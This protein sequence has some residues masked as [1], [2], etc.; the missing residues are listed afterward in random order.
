[1]TPNKDQPLIMTQTAMDAGFGNAD[2]VPIGFVIAEG[3]DDT[4]PFEA[5]RQDLKSRRPDCAI[6][7]H[8]RVLIEH[9]KE[10]DKMFCRISGDAYR[11]R[12]TRRPVRP[13]PT[14]NPLED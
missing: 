10:A 1:M 4:A 5:A 11:E 6:V 8:A 12:D 7:F 13:I 14:T 3:W 9:D 2:M